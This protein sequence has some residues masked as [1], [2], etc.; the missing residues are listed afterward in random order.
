M[1]ALPLNARPR[2]SFGSRSGQSRTG[3]VVQSGQSRPSG[4]SLTTDPLA[5]VS[6]WG[7]IEH[8]AGHA[9]HTHTAPAPLPAESDDFPAHSNSDLPLSDMV[10]RASAQLLIL[11]RT[12]DEAGTVSRQVRQTTTDLTQRLDHGQRLKTEIDQ[13]LQAAGAASGVL[14]K[15]SITLRGLEQLVSQIRVASGALEQK[16]SAKLAEQA[17]TFDRK[18]AELSDRFNARIAQITAESE[19]VASQAEHKLKTDTDRLGAEIDR[20]VAQ[21]QARSSLVLDSASDRVQTLERQAE[22]LGGVITQRVETMCSEAARVLGHDPRAQPREEPTPGSLA[23]RLT[24]TRALIKEAEDA[25][26]RLASL[27]GETEQASKRVRNAGEEARDAID[28]VASLREKAVAQVEH[29]LSRVHELDASLLDAGERHAKAIDRMTEANTQLAT[30]REDLGTMASAFGYHIS[31]ARD[32]Q[33][34]LSQTCSKAGDQ[35]RTLDD[36]AAHVAR[37]AQSLVAL[38]RDAATLIAQAQK[39]K[40]QSSVATEDT[41]PEHE[42]PQN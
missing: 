22:H 5:E 37:Q 21:V 41:V 24:T 11:R 36:A 3:R 9:Q 31:Q 4:P 38:A 42:D 8:K 29:A 15:A 7:V 6:P 2:S 10:D 39:P 14:E 33:Q 26:I 16:I 28:N 30:L 18:L 35:I 12:L 25:S 40:E 32:A 27:L 20:R 19:L 34:S 1:S 23:E 17:A 13:R